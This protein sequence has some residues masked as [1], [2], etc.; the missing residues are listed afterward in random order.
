LVVIN[1]FVVIGPSLS[2]ESLNTSNG[3]FKGLLTGGYPVIM[4]LS[5]GLV[6]VR[7]V[8]ISHINAMQIE[9]AN[10]RYICANTTLHMKD[11]VALLKEHYP[12]YKIPKKDLSCGVG[13][14]L[15]KIMSHFQEKGVKDFLKTNLGCHIEFDNS[16][17]VNGLKMEFRDINQTILETCE[18]LLESGF[19]DKIEE[20]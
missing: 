6:D 17:I 16:K 9:E 14:G 8:A 1:P 5:W 20:Q 19:V 12:Q 15:V 10:G 13:N 11:V 18:Y 4:N 7:D 2:N 3:I